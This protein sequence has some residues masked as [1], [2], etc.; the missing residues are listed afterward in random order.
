MKAIAVVDKNL[1]IGRRGGLIYHIPSDL[2]HF[3]RETL[4]KTLIMGRKTLESMPGGKPLKGRNTLVL[5]KNLPEGEF[6]REDGSYA[7]VFR[8]VEELLSFSGTDVVVCGGAQIYER[9]IG[10]CDELIMTEVEGETKDADAFFPEYRNTG[11]FEEYEDSGPV[12]EEGIR[13]HIRRYRKAGKK[14]PPEGGQAED[15][16]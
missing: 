12:E 7:R 5:S 11:T 6:W 13:Y 4:G 10:Y 9:F 2:K 8:T 1:A 16:A 3:R 14:F 15:R